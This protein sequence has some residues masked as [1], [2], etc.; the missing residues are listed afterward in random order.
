MESEFTAGDRRCRAV[1]L[2]TRRVI[3]PK[4]EEHE[5]WIGSFY[6]RLTHFFYSIMNEAPPSQQVVMTDSGA[7]VVSFPRR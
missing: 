4:D 2:L 3:Q 7:G 5:E 1:V 6:R